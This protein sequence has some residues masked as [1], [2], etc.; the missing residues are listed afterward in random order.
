MNDEIKFSLY[1]AGTM[2]LNSIDAKT[3]ISIISTTTL[4]ACTIGWDLA[5]AKT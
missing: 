1:V 5:S 4:P 2:T 3:T